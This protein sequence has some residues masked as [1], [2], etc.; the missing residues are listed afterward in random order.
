[1]SAMFS[2]NFVESK[3]NRTEVS[4]SNYLF[5]FVKFNAK[6]PFFKTLPD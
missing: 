5:V 3:N 2:G 4:Q 6:M 1:M